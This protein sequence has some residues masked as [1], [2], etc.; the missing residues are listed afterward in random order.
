MGAALSLPGERRYTIVTV[1]HGAKHVRDALAE[2]ADRVAEHC[3]ADG[4]H[5][6][7]IRNLHLIRC[8]R[9]SEPLHVLQ[10]PALCLVVQGR[11]QVQLGDRMF[12]YDRFNYL[13]V[14]VDVPLVGQVV[15]ASPLRPYLSV[16]LDLDPHVLGAL[17]L[18]LTA[19]KPTRAAGASLSVCSVT[20][21]LLDAVIRMVR[22]LESPADIAVLARLVEREILYRLLT[23]DDN[24]RLWQIAHADSKLL[25]VNRA[26]AWIKTNYARPLEVSSLAK[27]AHMSTSSLHQHFKRVTA[28]SPLQYQKQ[29]RLQEARRLIVNQACDASS[30]AH[31]V[32]YESPSQFSRE[33]RRL[34]GVPPLRDA[35]R[36]RAANQSIG[37]ELP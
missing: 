20:I 10:E 6:T 14:S 33:Y 16:R 18:E 35:A 31:R 7:H 30:A 2:L 22:L 12:E 36:L 32:G 13:V 25:Q 1:G 28:M 27:R 37:L 11:K 17:A 19:R 3:S 23:G 34:F 5:P 9:P 24:G 21:E 15:E 26:I 8:S 4:M 29:L